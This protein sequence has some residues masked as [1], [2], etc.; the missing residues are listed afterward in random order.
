MSMMNLL[1][2][3]LLYP[4]LY[5]PLIDKVYCVF[6]RQN[7]AASATHTSFRKTELKSKS[8][9]A[10]TILAFADFSSPPETSLKASQETP[11]YAKSPVK[12]NTSKA[13]KNT[14]ESLLFELSTPDEMTRSDQF[15]MSSTE[16]ATLSAISNELSAHHKPASLT[17]GNYTR[18]LMLSHHDFIFQD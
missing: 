2:K 16:N 17:K 7:T 11:I 8:G 15:G 4:T 6:R 5:L 13:A 12:E 3:T 18:T 10:G 9:S 1:H 14:L